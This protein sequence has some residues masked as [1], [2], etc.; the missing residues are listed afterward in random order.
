[1]NC[2]IYLRVSTKEQAEGGYSISAQREA[3]VKYVCDKGWN[4][5]DEYADCG[6]SARSADRPQL[7]EMLHRVR[8]D[9]SIDAI[10]VHKLDRL[11]RNIEDHAAIRAMLRKNKV[12]MVSVTENLEDSASG[13]LNRPGFIG[14]SVA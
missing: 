2:L 9:E 12:Q 11:A 1:M 8:K 3:L 7:Q 4:L 13:K 10:I 5:V 6:E 14:G